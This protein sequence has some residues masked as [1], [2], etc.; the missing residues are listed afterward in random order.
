MMM[1]HA[2]RRAYPSALV[3]LM[4]TE[5]RNE[6]VVGVVRRRPRRR[7]ALRPPT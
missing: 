7:H 4:G 1:R 2:A 6:K 3:R 5:A